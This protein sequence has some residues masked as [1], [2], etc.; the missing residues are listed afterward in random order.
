M[1]VK[2]SDK[3][4]YYCNEEMSTDQHPSCRFSKC[5]LQ[6]DLS[7]GKN[8]P[9]NFSSNFKNCRTYKPATPVLILSDT[10][11]GVNSCLLES[12]ARP[13][14][15]SSISLIRSDLTNT[16][17]N[18][19]ERDLTEFNKINSLC[20]GF[21]Q[22]G[23]KETDSHLFL[24]LKQ[25][26]SAYS[27]SL[28]SRSDNLSPSVCSND[29]DELDSGIGLLPTLEQNQDNCDMPLVSPSSSTPLSPCSSTSLLTM[30]SRGL[31]IDSNL[32]GNRKL[33]S[34][35]TSSFR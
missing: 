25:Y 16:E 34:T 31:Q 11:T 10:S 14:C 22:N 20:N 21:L 6:E 35:S 23:T 7:C 33:S 13:G 3:E 12:N 24:S 15:N 9:M 26:D 5:N 28:E 4:T 8:R 1:L 19:A 2:C 30:E 27:S 32:Q 29:N 18:T 17:K